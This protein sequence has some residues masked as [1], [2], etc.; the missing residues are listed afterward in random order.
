MSN[1]SLEIERFFK[2]SKFNYVTS[3]FFVLR[4]P[5]EGGVVFHAGGG[6]Y[7]ALSL[8]FGVS[9]YFSFITI[10]V[11]QKK[12]DKKIRPF[13]QS[14]FKFCLMNFHPGSIF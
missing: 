2:V 12:P 4:F 11:L 14:Y 3:L 9:G 13:F 10:C 8:E 1:L 7:Q 5:T 6:L